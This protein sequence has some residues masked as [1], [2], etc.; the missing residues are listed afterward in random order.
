MTDTVY[1]MLWVGV[2]WEGDFGLLLY[3]FCDTF[4]SGHSPRVHVTSHVSIRGPWL[5]RFRVPRGDEHAGRTCMGT[6]GKRPSS[7]GCCK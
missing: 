7:K 6:L 2:G 4:G 1:G 3:R 5:V